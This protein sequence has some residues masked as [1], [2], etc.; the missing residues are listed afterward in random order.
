MNFQ[1]VLILSRKPLNERRLYEWLEESS[2]SVV[3][4][5]THD[6]LLESPI[7]PNKEFLATGVVEDYYSWS[8]EL[9]AESHG[10]LHNID[11]IASSSEDDVLRA[12]RVR[13]RLGLPGQSISSAVAFRD[14][15]IMKQYCST[16]GVSVPRFAAIDSAINLLTFAEEQGFP[17]VVK[18]R[19]GAGSD[20][21]QIL[22]NMNELKIFAASGVLSAVPDT[23]GRWMAETYVQGEF[24]HIDGVMEAGKILHCWPSHYSS[25]NLETA[26][27]STLLWSIM[28]GADDPIHSKLNTFAQQVITTLPATLFPTSFHLEAWITNDGPIFC[29]VASRTGG[30]PIARSY[31]EAFGIHLS[32]ESL[33]GQAGRSLE[34]TA[35]PSSP[36]RYTGWL[37]VPPGHG[38]FVPPSRN[39]PVPESTITYNL[40]PGTYCS[41]AQ[42]LGDSAATVIVAAESAQEVMNRVQDVLK[43]WQ[44]ESRWVV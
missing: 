13:E 26:K 9:V 22:T 14:K 43:W 17:I 7:I 1:R 30:G 24:Y 44:S 33:R 16:A 5:T 12:A 11:L 3:L 35:Q 10:H 42:N 4:I 39:C 25:G 40:E 36:K 31:F 32:K 38:R 2:K 29:E 21:V 41:G 18:P 8:V 23:S 34:L 19:Y 20:G 15:L 28:V 6:A 37:L 27:N